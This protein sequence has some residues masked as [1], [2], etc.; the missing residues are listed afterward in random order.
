MN[1][2][3]IRFIIGQLIL[4]EGVLMSLPFVVC[5][6][7]GEWNTMWS[8]LI[9]MLIMILV[10]S[11]SSI[12]KPKNKTLSAKEGF[13]I[14]GLSWIILSAVGCIPFVVSGLI[15]N[16][17]NAFFET[18]SGFTTTGA[19]VLESADF[20][21]LWSPQDAADGMRGI[22]FWRS[23]TN[24]IG[25]MGVLVFVLAVMPQQDMKSSRLVHIMKAEMPGPKIE[26][27]LP[28]VKK[29]ALI[30]Y[31][32]YVVMTLTQ[33]ALLLFGGMDLYEALC[34]SFSTAGTGGFAIWPDGMMSFGGTVAY[35]E[36][37][38][39][40][41]S[42][43]MFLFSINFNLYYLIITGSF[44]TAILSEELRWFCGIVLTSV[45]LITL[46]LLYTGT[47]TSV[48]DSIRDAMFQVASIISTSGFATDDFNLWPN[49]SKII[50]LVLMFIGACA[51]STGGGIKVSR[52]L[53]SIKGAFS[54]IGH[55]IAP[56]RIKKVRFEGKC[57]DEGTLHGTYAYMVMYAVIFFASFIAVAMLDNRDIETTFSAIATCINNIGPGLGDVGPA[58]SFKTISLLSKLI[59]SLDMLIGRLEIF[60]ILLLFSPN[61]WKRK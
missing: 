60:P 18:V 59:L 54:E 2:R 56:R 49:F 32:I 51:G 42:V 25:G 22:F 20:A 9:P 55:M 10:G 29:T 12:F 24:W 16:Y 44:L 7:Y 50:M 57:V 31:L 36:Y 19:S 26:K 11:I 30:M 52:I 58:S 40:V 47:Y 48:N 45:I 27:V 38:V 53:I 34:T 33:V 39:W 17:I 15:P 1:Y 43:F 6:W 3:M 37:C 28:T 41:I 23:F 21:K 35:T 14:V 5:L 61:V 13:V 46:N 4:A 8:I